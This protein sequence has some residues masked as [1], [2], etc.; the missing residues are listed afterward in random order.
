MSSG[1]KSAI[2]GTVSLLT[3]FGRAIRGVRRI[4]LQ[5]L[6]QGLLDLLLTFLEV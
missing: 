6:L 1:M 4:I 5:Q 3:Q 2:T